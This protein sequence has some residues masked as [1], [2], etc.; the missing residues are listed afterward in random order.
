L[1][2][3]RAEQKSKA[4]QSISIRTE[5]NEKAILIFTVVTVIFL[6][7]SFVTGYLGMNVEDIRNLS[8]T[9]SLFWVISMPITFVIGT[10]VLLL[11]GSNIRKWI[12]MVKNESA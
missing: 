6:P 10:I 4:R 1:S 9:Q 2:T 7:L 5:S 12:F 8:K 3:S 11:M